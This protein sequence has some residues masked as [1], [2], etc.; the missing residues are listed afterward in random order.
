MRPVSYLK[1]IFIL[2]ISVNQA[3]ASQVILLKQYVEM[4]Q[5]KDPSL[6]S[7]QV[8]MEGSRLIKNNARLLTGINFFTKGNILTDGRPTSAPSFQ[9]DQTDVNAV[10][11]GLQ[12]QTSF[13]LAWTLSQ[14]Y[15]YT[16]I[17]NAAV[18][19]LPEYYDMYPKIELSLPLWRNWLG[20]ETKATQVQAE[21]QIRVQMLNSEL[22]RVQKENEV[23]EAYYSLATQQ[24]SFEIQKDSLRR[25]EKILNWARS[26]ATRNLSDKSDVYQTQALVSARKLELMSAELKLKEAARV[27]NSFLEIDSDTV[28]YSLAPEEIDL[29]ALELSKVQAKAR[30]DLRL[31]K[32]NLKSVESSYIVQRE[33]N[34]PSLNVSMAYLKQGRDATVSGAQSKISEAKDYRLLTLTFN[35]PLDIGNMSDSQEG[36]GKLAEGQVLAEKASVRAESIQWKNTVNQAETL[37]QQLKIVRDLEVVQKNKADLERSKYNNGRSTTYQVLMFEQDYVNSRTQKI[38][39]ELQVRKFLTSLDLYR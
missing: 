30:L 35:M 38:N 36:Y 18:V 15:Q 4:A 9:G 3:L 34:K 13:G 24:K 10:A 21:S 23:K 12:Q 25:A 27:F 17:Y 6:Q 19:P 22:S 37:A 20:S 39:L 26:R 29:Q 1:L 7:A 32:E 11:V 16:K 2:G 8:S 31:Q 14:N 33:K 28:S 5:S